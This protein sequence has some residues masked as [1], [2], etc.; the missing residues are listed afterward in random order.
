MSR[1]TPVGWHTDFR[2]E[3]TGIPVILE[4]YWRHR[5]LF[6]VEP[7]IG[8][9]SQ[10]RRQAMVQKDED[11]LKVLCEQAPHE[12]DGKKLMKLVAEITDLLD[13]KQQ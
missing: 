11:L 8:R 7:L 1:D 5:L 3:N 4:I 13:G 6:R 10:C 12:Q 9:L 2:A